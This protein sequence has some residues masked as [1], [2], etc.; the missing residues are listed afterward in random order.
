MIF[1][2]Q[3]R[4]PSRVAC[5]PERSEGSRSMGSQ[6]LRC[7]QHDTTGFG[8]SS[9]LSAPRRSNEIKQERIQVELIGCNTSQGIGVLPRERL[10]K[11]I[12]PKRSIKI[13]GHQISPGTSANSIKDANHE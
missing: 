2:N 9:S 8:R 5:H 10:K 6:M 13:L 11:V 4:E 1:T 3:D 7:A 12:G